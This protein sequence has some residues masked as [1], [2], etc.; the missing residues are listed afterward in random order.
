MIIVVVVAALAVAVVHGSAGGEWNYSPS[1]GYGPAHWHKVKDSDAKPYSDCA[2]NSQS[3]INFGA[4]DVSAGLSPVD[5]QNWDTAPMAAGAQVSN[6]GHTIK[7]APTGTGQKTLQ[8]KDPNGGGKTYDLLQ[9]HFHGPSEHTFGGGLRDMEMHMV[10]QAADGSY[11]VIGVTFIATPNG[12]NSFLNHFWETIPGLN[13]EN[14]GTL[15]AAN[16]TKHNFYQN[17]IL[18]A[19]KNYFTYSGSFTTPPCT[20]GV[21]W[22]VMEEANTMSTAQLAAFMKTINFNSSVWDGVSQFY[23][24]GTY[25]PAQPLND[26]IVRKYTTTT[27]GASILSF[28]LGTVVA[29]LTTS[30][31]LL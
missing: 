15:P 4:V 24:K 10:H 18:P 6:N 27:S 17:G 25:R 1:S 16:T 11:L 20:E 13:Y 12:G 2:K 5:L 3:P 9:F 30:V 23:S 19:S 31:L 21:T 8:L 28:A 26:R 29:M 22:Y 14:G 7:M